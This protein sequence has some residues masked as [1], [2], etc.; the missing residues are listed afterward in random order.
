MLPILVFQVRHY[1]LGT[2]VRIYKNKPQ[3]EKKSTFGHVCPVKKISSSES[4]SESKFITDDTSND[5]HS[6]GAVGS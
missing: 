3:R 4:E 2:S 1:S 6:P 5:I